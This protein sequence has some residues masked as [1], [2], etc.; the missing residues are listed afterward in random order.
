MNSGSLASQHRFRSG[1]LGAPRSGIKEESPQGS[2][3]IRGGEY[4][5]RLFPKKRHPKKLG[6]KKSGPK[7]A[8]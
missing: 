2:G 8:F 3:D 5:T 6:N 7:T 1:G 4:P